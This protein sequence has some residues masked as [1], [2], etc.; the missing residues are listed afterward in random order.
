MLC[1]DNI[2]VQKGQDECISIVS[3]AKKVK[4][5]QTTSVLLVMKHRLSE[6]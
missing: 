1:V 4:L 5:N 3:R 2:G 6:T